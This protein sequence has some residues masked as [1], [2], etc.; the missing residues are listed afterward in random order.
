MGLPS[1]PD[2]VEDLVLSQPLNDKILRY[3]RRIAPRLIIQDDLV[4]FSYS[5]D[6]WLQKLGIHENFADQE[7]EHLE[8]FVS[9]S[10]RHDALLYLAK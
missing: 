7:L 3:G 9:I 10:H 5:I 1:V 6:A 8:L 4:E 2:Q